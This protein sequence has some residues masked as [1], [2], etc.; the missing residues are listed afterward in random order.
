MQLRYQ[1]NVQK[2]ADGMQKVTSVAWSP[3]K[4]RL[5]VVT[6]D[7]IVQLYDEN[8]DKKDRFATKPADKAQRTYVVRAMAF[9][10]CST[11]LAIA[12]SDNIVFIY[13]LGESWADKK[14]ICNKFPQTS[15]VNCLTWPSSRPSEVVF[16]LAEG[17]VKIGQL[18]SNKAATLYSAE[19]SFCISLASS[20]SGNAI[21]S[22]HLDGSIYRFVF[23]GPGSG[24][25]AGKLCTVPSP[26]QALAWGQAISVGGT[27]GIV[28]F[29]TEE[30]KEQARF[31]AT[32]P[33]SGGAGM[34]AKDFTCASFSPSGESV[35]VG[36]FNQFVVYALKQT[37]RG[38]QWDVAVQKQIK[39]LYSVTAL[40][41]K[42]DG[43]KLAVGSLCGSVDIFD[44][45]MRRC[46]YRNTHEF[47]YIST[48]AV[49]VTDLR[50]QKSVTVKSSGG[51]EISK[52]NVFQDRYLVAHTSDSIILCDLEGEIEAAAQGKKAGGKTS[53]V[54]TRRDEAVRAKFNFD[55]SHIC[56]VFRAGELMIIEYGKDDPIGTVRTEVMSP[57]LVSVRV[58]VEGAGA[59]SGKGRERKQIIA[60]LL[61][62]QTIRI[63]DLGTQAT[64]GT[65]NHDS[66]I[67]FLEL[68]HMGD[69][70]I[71]RDKRKQL[72]LFNCAEQDRA[73]LLNF[74]SYVQW[75]PL[76]D[77]VVAQSRSQLC[78]WYSISAPDKVTIHEVGGEVEQITREPGRTTVLVE[79][80]GGTVGYELD[81][82]LIS[83]G[84][85]AERGLF[86]DAVDL[87]SKLPLTGETEALWRQL[88]SKALE[89]EELAV[90]EACCATVGDVARARFIHKTI[91]IA[92]THAAETGSNGKSY[93]VVQARLAM[94]VKHFQRAEAL[95]LDNGG[96]ADAMAMYEELHRFDDALR[97]AEKHAHPQVETLRQRY[98]QHLLT[99]GQEESAA[100]LEEKRGRYEETIELYLRGGL[101]AKAAAIVNSHPAQYS[102]Q[103][104]QRIASAL[105]SSGLDGRA[106]ELYEKMGMTAPALESYRRGRTYRKAVELARSA[107]PNEVVALEEEWA[108]W[109]VS[110]GQYDAAVN[111]FIEANEHRKAIEACMSARLWNRAEELVDQLSLSTGAQG[112]LAPSDPSVQPLLLRIAEHYAKARQLGQAERLYVKA[113][114]ASDAVTLYL[115]HRQVQEA[116]RVARSHLDEKESKELHRKLAI[117]LEAEGKLIEAEELYVAG[118]DVDLAIHMYKK[119]E[120]FDQML[121]LVAKYRANLLND[122]Y[123]VLAEHMEMKGNLVMAEHYYIDAGLWQ[124]AVAM[125]R[126]LGRW[127]DAKR[128]ARTQGG[129]AALHK[130]VLAH[131]QTVARE[132]D[133]ANGTAKDAGVQLLLRHNFPELAVDYVLEHKNFAYAFELA[134]AH[135]KSRLQDVHLKRALQMEDDN[136]FREAEEDFIAAGRPKEAIEMYAYGGDWMSA[137][138]VA[139]NYHPASVPEI[140]VKHAQE[141]AEKGNTQAAEALFVAAQKSELAVQ[142]YISKGLF[143]DAVRVCKRYCP[144]LLEEVMQAAAA[145]EGGGMGNTAGGSRSEGGKGGASFQDLMETGR[146]FEQTGNFQ[147]AIATYLSIDLATAQNT[148]NLEDAMDRAVRLAAQ[149]AKE[150]Y[151]DVAGAAA[152]RLRSAELYLA[153]A[154]LFE[155]AQKH[156]EAVECLAAAEKWSEAISLAQRHPRTREL[157]PRLEEAQRQSL[158]G[159]NDERGLLESGNA[160]AVLDLLARQGEWARCLETAKKQAPQ[161]LPHYALQNVKALMKAK[162]NIGAAAVLL[163]YELPMSRDNQTAELCSLLARE[164]LALPSNVAKGASAKPE[165]GG[166][167]AYGLCRDALIHLLDP[168]AGP[169]SFGAGPL[170]DRSVPLVMAF[171]KSIWTAHLLHT[172]LRCEEAQ[173]GSLSTKQAIALLRYCTEFPVDRAFF[174][175]GMVCKREGWMDMA[176]LFLN[177]FLDIADAIED[178]DTAQIDNADFKDTDIPSPFEVELPES[179]AIDK[180]TREQTKNL[181]LNWG[182]DSSV[183]DAKERTSRCDNCGEEVY[184]AACTCPVCKHESDP[185]IVTGFPVKKQTRMECRSCGSAANSPDWNV[186]VRSTGQCPWCG[187]QADAGT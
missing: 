71:F 127:D 51:Y 31:T 164:L 42:E 141:K 85:C 98:L 34:G 120:T 139:E 130:V 133:S 53:E 99:T 48:S 9:S 93:F 80:P 23:E 180:E 91:Q 72:H 152:E 81:E 52:I 100:L 160:L 62:L 131:A 18:K 70:L 45:S 183:S 36:S 47:T 89:A 68:N 114:R 149:N 82:A 105:T 179:N 94:L 146:A 182:V 140:K 22:G 109:L 41:W 174:D 171:G 78:V 56:L 142:M 150:S 67:D 129:Q 50:S 90:A 159:R 128:V 125:H 118:G 166:R 134:R 1:K 144:Q 77:V 104:L 103:L 173:M 97:L 61:D 154:P 26:P 148:R 24:P 55:Y 79:E 4:M 157:V 115:N 20:P 106:G 165:T 87:L 75:V 35:A 38:R 121:R 49:L 158:V 29:Y 135:C 124:N 112:P 138:R 5:A 169:G 84:A 15:P 107:R 126:N 102:P 74:C 151:P 6:V 60:F 37:A 113:G 123:K 145:S 11:K 186:F 108:D 117:K 111:H 176:F 17:R 32:G 172:R 57:H 59:T 7:R 8:G 88:A 163:Q 3:N 27:D 65:V 167:D 40:A 76:S 28:R 16:G 119:R 177:R 13:K 170:R 43:S 96:L 116:Q 92:A 46:R 19:G 132:N 10:P 58:D 95:L 168:H 101:A 12:Q 155:H 39:N 14:S 21:I 2:P 54:L 162:D 73:T 122:T 175:A 156:R 181:V 64:L 30:G 185:C 83:F 147:R 178:P 137:E 44:A 143:P 86:A 33:Q 161:K 66:K 25:I 184:E 187:S 63:L 153:A 136:R 110:Q 69:K